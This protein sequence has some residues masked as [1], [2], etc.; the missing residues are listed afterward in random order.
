MFCR[1]CRH[2]DGGRTCIHP[3]VMA[4]Y[5]DVVTGE[6]HQIGMRCERVRGDK[7]C[8]LFGLASIFTRIV[9]GRI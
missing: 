6:R 3:E 1:D 8:R 5:T 4:E 2:Y 7:E 9:R